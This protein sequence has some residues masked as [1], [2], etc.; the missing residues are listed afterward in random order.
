M[1]RCCSLMVKVH[2][3]EE[4]NESLQN[5]MKRLTSSSKGR[6]STTSTSAQP[7]DKSSRTPGNLDNSCR[8]EPDGHASAKRTRTQAETPN[9]AQEALQN[10]AKRL[11][12]ATPQKG[13]EEEEFTPEGLPDR[14]MKG[15]GDIPRG[16]MSPFIMRRTTV[17][18]CSPRLAAQKSTAGLQVSFS[19]D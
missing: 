11:K 17:Q 1:D 8:E 3:L 15:F 9:K 14:V 12:A 6:R 10:L 5:K 4:A 7:E 18:R 2:K 13:L 19:A 16:E